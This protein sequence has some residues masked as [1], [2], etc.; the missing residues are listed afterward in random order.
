MIYGQ[1]ILMF[2]GLVYFCHVVIIVNQHPKRAKWQVLVGRV[3]VRLTVIHLK[4]KFTLDAM[5]G[6]EA[7]I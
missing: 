3:L 4:Q 6:D 5:L 1:L 7:L 2:K